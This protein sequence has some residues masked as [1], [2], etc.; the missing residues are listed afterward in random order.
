MVR[1]YN[2]LYPCILH[3]IP[4][5]IAKFNSAVRGTL[6]D[7]YNTTTQLPITTSWTSMIIVSNVT[8]DSTNAASAATTGT[9]LLEVGSPLFYVVVGA[10]SGILIVILIIFILCVV[11]GCS[12]LTARK[13]RT[14]SINLAP[15]LGQWTYSE[16]REI[17]EQQRQ[18]QIQGV[19][20]VITDVAELEPA[21]QYDVIVDTSGRGNNLWYTV[22]YRCIL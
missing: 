22:E 16:R 20:N 2:S 6:D 11:I 17:L 13:E 7:T 19:Y 15:T 4:H 10:G 5:I 21:S 14:Y 18:S 3:S 9:H 1:I 8:G 12:C